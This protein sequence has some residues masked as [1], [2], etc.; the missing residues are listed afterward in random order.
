MVLLR[1]LHDRDHQGYFDG[2]QDSPGLPP[3][4]LEEILEH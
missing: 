4:M 3:M 1:L 2:A